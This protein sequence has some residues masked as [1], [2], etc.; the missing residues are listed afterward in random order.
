M[1]DHATIQ[2]IFDSSD[3]VEVISDF[4]NLK[5]SGSSFKA[6]SPFTNEKTPSFMVSPSKQI[7]KCFSSGIGGNA[8]SFL[9][10]HEKLTYPEALK[11]LAKKYNIPIVEK[12][13]TQEEIQQENER[14]SLMIV[15]SFAQKYFTEKLHTH[16][17]GKAIGY[18]YLKE[19]GFRENIIEKFQLGYCLNQRNA[20]TEEARRKGYKTDML[21]KSGLTVQRENNRFDRFSGRVIFPIHGLSGKVVGFGGRVLKKEE[22][23]AKYLNSPESEIY[24]KSKILYGLFFAKKSIIQKDKCFLVEGYTDVISLFQNEIENVVASSGTALTQDQIRLIKRFTNN[25]TII[26]DGDEA[27][28]KASFRGIDLVLEEGLNVKVLLLPDGEDPDSFSKKHSAS[29][30]EKFISDNEQDFIT[31]KSNL[32]FTKDEKIDPVKRAGLINEIVKSIALVPD[33]ITRT[34]YIQECSKILDIEEKFLFT[35]TNKI[36]RQKRE[37][38][39]K[40]EQYQQKQQ[41]INAPISR[42]KL[43]EDDDVLEKDI[44]EILLKNGNYKIFFEKTNNPDDEKDISIIEYIIDEIKNDEIK[45]S[46]AFFEQIFNE[47]VTFTDKSAYIDE[48]Y[49][50]HHKDEKI[51]KLA[52]DVLTEPYTLSKL[53]FKNEN[54]IETPEMRLKYYVPDVVI[55]YKTKKI[56]EAIKN[57]QDD[58]KQA[59]ENKEDEKIIQFLNRL[60]ML[61]DLKKTLAKNLGDRIILR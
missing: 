49:F 16:E 30:F 32:L 42:E 46:N 36:L 14:E 11:Y 13:R 9:M 24:H 45:F 27:G 40:R 56:L 37:K 51:A 12:E 6:N 10:E 48:R 18:K 3:I 28:I 39:F 31:F 34:V 26:Y 60:M 54:H 22:K 8:V 1:I 44:I 61:N 21:V 2:K 57:T 5:K 50:I 7:F 52:A 23:T 35:E 17:E 15:T 33:S 29:E 4:V 47:F 55:S 59:Q 43:N 58:L 38:N 20:F 41:P 53:W 25:I 19:R